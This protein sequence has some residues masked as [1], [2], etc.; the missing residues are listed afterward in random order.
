MNRNRLEARGEGLWVLHFPF[1]LLGANLGKTTTVMRLASGELAVH[2]GAPFAADDVA[3]IR[4]LGPVRW[5]LEATRMH[6]TFAPDLRRAFPEAEMLVPAG[7]PVTSETIAP[8]RVLGKPPEAWAGE[9]EVLPLRGI[10]VMREFAVLHRA[11]RT[12]VLADLIFNLPLAP[13]E[14]VPFFLRW[15]SGFKRF[16]GTSRLVRMSVRDRPAF[17]RS[18]EALLACDIERVV[19]G[20]GEVIEQDAKRILSEALSWAR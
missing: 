8:S 11:S 2:S 1:R 3:A 10:P 5:V 17:A 20:H 9:I 18:V 15:V 13:E 4:S 16:P 14:R 19:V 7:F 12:L 6:D